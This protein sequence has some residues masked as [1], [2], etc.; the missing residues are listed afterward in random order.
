M[1]RILTVALCLVVVGLA[2]FAGINLLWGDGFA[3]ISLP[4]GGRD[5]GVINNFH[6]LGDAR[7]FTVSTGDGGEFPSAS[8]L[9]VDQMKAE[10]D[11]IVTFAKESGFNTLFFR[12]AT[13]GGATTAPRF[14]R[15]QRS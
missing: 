11:E 5:G 15:P 8:G 6:Y 14:W 4:W 9:T 12:P 10:L 2:V 3:G 13:A 1:K 7:G